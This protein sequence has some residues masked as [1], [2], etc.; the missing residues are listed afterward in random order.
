MSNG[1]NISMTKKKR[2]DCKRKK[3][4]IEKKLDLKNLELKKKIRR[5]EKIKINLKKIKN[6]LFIILYYYYS[7]L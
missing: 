7:I 6:K 3:K 4:K 5:N 1:K 2:K